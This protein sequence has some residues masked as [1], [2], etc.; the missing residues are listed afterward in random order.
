MPPMMSHTTKSQKGEPNER[1]MPAGV[2]KIPTAMTSPTTSAAMEVKPSWRLSVPG[3]ASTFFIGGVKCAAPPS[4]QGLCRISL[5][6]SAGAQRVE[7]HSDVD[8][9]LQQCTDDR[10][11]DADGGEEHPHGAQ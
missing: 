7:Y 10:R 4:R 2:R 3:E 1:A 9:L 11:D 6:H 8:P 5:R